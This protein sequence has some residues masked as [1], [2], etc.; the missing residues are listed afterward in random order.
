MLSISSAG[1]QSPGTYDAVVTDLGAVEHN[2]AHAN[3]HIVAHGA[4]VDNGAVS[5]GAAGTHY[6]LLMENGPVLDV[7]ALPYG[8]GALV[9][10]QDGIVPDADPLAQGHISHHGSAGADQ[11]ILVSLSLFVSHGRSSY[12]NFAARPPPPASL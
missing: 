8:D 1:N 7:G 6:R 5:N 11:N 10:P 9:S 3:Q 12:V 4:A 2:S